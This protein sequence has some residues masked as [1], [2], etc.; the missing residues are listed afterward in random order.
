MVVAAPPS[1]ET[2]R[3]TGRILY[4]GTPPAPHKIDFSRANQPD[5]AGRMNIWA[6]AD[7]YAKLGIVAESTV[8]DDSGGIANVIIWVRSKDVPTP[9]IDKSTP[10][11]T[12][13][14]K[15]GRFDPHVLVF[16][17]AA[18]LVFRNQME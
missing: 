16:W 1:G 5:N 6:S 3:L 10:P 11:V 17:K 14:A 13:C 15:D 8:V 7:R 12:L 9:P 2:G 4:G 18:P